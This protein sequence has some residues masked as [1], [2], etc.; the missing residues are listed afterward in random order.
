MDNIATRRQ[1]LVQMLTDEGLDLLL[2]TN[3]INVSYLTHFSGEL[4]K[5]LAGVDMIHV[6]A[7]GEMEAQSD[8]LADRAQV[9]FDPMVSSLGQIRAGKLRALAVTSAQRAAMLPD[10][11]SIA[12]FVPGYVVDARLDRVA[13]IRM[14]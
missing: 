3:P 2:V 10:V 9:M 4:F 13:V 7:H 5:M 11:P 6:P 1:R 12:E 8:L 14:G